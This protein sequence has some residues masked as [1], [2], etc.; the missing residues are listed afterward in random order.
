MPHSLLVLLSYFII[1]P[2]CCA[3]A[4]R[5]KLGRLFIPFML[6]LVAG[7]CN[8][9]ASTVRTYTVQ[10][11]SLN[12]NIYMLIEALL[13]CWQFQRWG[14]FRKSAPLFGGLMA[15]LLL[16]WVAEITQFAMPRTLLYFSMYYCFILSVCSIEMISRLAGRKDLA[17]EQKTIFKISTAF[18][19][20]FMCRLML[21]SSWYL[22]VAMSAHFQRAVFDVMALINVAINLAY[23]MIIL[24]IPGKQ[25]YT[26]SS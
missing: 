19:I 22:G 14:A 8:E 4:G 25:K 12:T 18:M 10:D 17:W 11:S 7:L 20:Y 3:V 6:F 1:I 21:D 15:S 24:W 26:T 13:L 9:I 16:T 5:A 2:V 23:A